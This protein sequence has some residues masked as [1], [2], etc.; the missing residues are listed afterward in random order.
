MS[1]LTELQIRTIH[2]TMLSDTRLKG[3]TP[4]AAICIGVF[5]WPNGQDA[6]IR[7]LAKATI[8]RAPKRVD[9]GFACADVLVYVSGDYN[10]KNTSSTSHGEE[11]TG[12]FPW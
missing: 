11:L 7:Q 1:S 12:G 9:S 8:K 10:V 2:N 3:R 4:T 6:I 5:G